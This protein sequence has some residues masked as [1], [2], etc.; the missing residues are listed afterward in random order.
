MPN[1]KIEFCLKLI[2]FICLIAIIFAYYVEYILGH[3][4]CNLCIIQRIPYI[5]SLILILINYRFKINQQNLILSLLFIFIFSSII[6]I[7]HLG[8]EQGFFQES[9]ICD[10]KNS[11][12]ILSKEELLKQLQQKNI[13]C[14]DVTFRIVGFSLTSINIVISLILTLLLT[15]IFI[16]YEKKK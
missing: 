4:P 10:I 16:S 5:L 6:S 8:I 14:K 7:Y 3:Q 9:L 12:N 13:S 11:A 1:Y 15:K 2:F